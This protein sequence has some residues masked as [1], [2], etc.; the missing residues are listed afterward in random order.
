MPNRLL[1]SDTL[2]AMVRNALRMAEE[3]GISTSREDLLE[4]CRHLPGLSVRGQ[5]IHVAQRT[6]CELLARNQATAPAL[7]AGHP[8]MKVASRGMIFADHHSGELRPLTRADVVAGTRLIE[9]LSARDRCVVGTTCG[10]PQEAILPLQPLEHYLIGY[11]YSRR[12]G[13]T[14]LPPEGEAAK[15][16]EEMREIAEDDYD[17]RRR[18]VHVWVPN[19]LKLEGNELDALLD[20][21]IQPLSLYVGSMPV[22]GLTGPA[23]PV[24]VYTLSLAETLAGTAILSLVYPEARATIFPHPEPMDLHSGMMAFGTLEWTRLELMQKEIMEHLGLAPH[25]MDVLT[26]ACM[27]DA[28]AQIDKSTSVTLG[29]MHGYTRFG[30][31]PL[32]GDEAYSPVQVLFDVEIVHRA[33]DSCRADTSASQADAAYEAVASA[34]R[35]GLIVGELEETA[36]QLRAHYSPSTLPRV[37]SSGQWNAAGRRQLLAEAEARVAELIAKAD[38]APPGDRYEKVLAVYHRACRAYGEG[39]MAL[40]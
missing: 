11:R 25:D 21:G 17:T 32:C 12:G 22:M 7:A 8:T 40:E 23:D 19:S 38:Y 26:S 24:G 5:R 31:C 13:D 15:Y 33:W 3:I 6:I 39:P 16:L 4:R 14:L 2:D 27:P 29:V 20:S 10:I 18:H 1:S 28:Q 36:R 9:A 30:M 35:A 37:H 34:M